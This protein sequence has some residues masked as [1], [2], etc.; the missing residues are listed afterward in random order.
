M[1]WT[2]ILERRP[3]LE[4]ET[5]FCLLTRPSPPTAAKIMVFTNI[6]YQGYHFQDKK[7]EIL[8][9]ME[10]IFELRRNLAIFG[11]S[12]RSCRS[13]DTQY[14][15]PTLSR[16]CEVGRARRKSARSPSFTMEIRT[17]SGLRSQ[18]PMSHT[19]SNPNKPMRSRSSLWTD[20][21]GAGQ[22]G[23]L[24]LGWSEKRL[25]E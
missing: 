11:R 24:L 19:A 17:P 25:R 6:Q 3:G 8:L 10:S 1:P 14:G 13:G 5:I 22:W 18:T 23:S 16:S 7:P 9:K 15:K 20:L 2:P 4:G 12:C 21:S